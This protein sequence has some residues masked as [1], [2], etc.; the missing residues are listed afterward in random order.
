MPLSA[1]HHSLAKANQGWRVNTFFPQREKENEKEVVAHL[2][3]LSVYSVKFWN[4]SAKIMA[5][6]FLPVAACYRSRRQSKLV[7][8][9]H[10]NCSSKCLLVLVIPFII[11]ASHFLHIYSLSN[12]TVFIVTVNLEESFPKTKPCQTDLVVSCTRISGK[13]FS[14]S[15]ALLVRHA[16]AA[17]GS[18]GHSKCNATLQGDSSSWWSL[19]TAPPNSFWLLLGR[20]SNACT[21]ACRWTVN[22]WSWQEWNIQ[23][24]LKGPR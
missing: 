12:G 1:L 14:S 9:H 18:V 8:K 7:E 13:L 22:Y 17:V 5:M 4:A 11:I 21:P 16:N 3:L 19:K 10:V 2:V 15:A 6:H 24:S 23:A 20:L